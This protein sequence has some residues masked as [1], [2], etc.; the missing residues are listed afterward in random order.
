MGDTVKTKRRWA[1]VVSQ[2]ET[3][4][5]LHLNEDATQEQLTAA[6]EA[7]LKTGMWRHVSQ[8]RVIH[9]VVE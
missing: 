6:V 7:A 2:V 5:E 8:P 3:I 9:E 4:V 1:N